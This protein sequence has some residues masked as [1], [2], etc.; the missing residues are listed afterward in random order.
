MKYNMLNYLYRR[1]IMRVILLKDVKGTGKKG[2]IKNVA[3]GYGKNFLL[4][5]GL[6]SL[7]TTSAVSENKSQKQAQDYH[8]EQERLAAVA[9]AEKIEGC[10]VK[11]GVKCGENGKV[12]GA[13]T[14]KEISDGLS[15]LGFDVPKQ[16][17]ELKEPIKMAGEYNLSARLYPGVSASFNVVVETK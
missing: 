7:A 5:N 3:D 1:K 16:K 2:E 14:S 10:T 15:A 8:K 6:A 11:V 13:V 12:F 9:L 17:I 4:K